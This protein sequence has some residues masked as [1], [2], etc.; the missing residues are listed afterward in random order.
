MSEQ[1]QNNL[2]AAL[3]AMQKECAYVQKGGRNQAQGY[4][5]ASAADV[6]RHVNEAACE[7]ALASFPSVDLLDCIQV[8]TRNGQTNLATVRVTMT[9]VHAPSGER[10]T[11]SALGQ[12]ADPGDKAVAKAQTMA[13]KYAWML[14]LNISTGDD[15]EA[16]E[17]TDRGHLDTPQPQGA[18]R[19][20]VA[21]QNGTSRPPSG[22]VPACPKC[23]GQMWDNR[24]KKT[25]PKAPDFKCKDKEHCDGATWV[26][27]NR[28]PSPAPQ[29]RTIQQA[30][31][32]DAAY[33]EQMENTAFR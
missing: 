25:N 22:D 8:P 12:G 5:Y 28:A 23:G 21:H 4:N 20:P 32:E 16:D 30:F 11:V 2:A 26:Q 13:I 15:P 17:S 1:N 10:L 27:S 33:A 6:L 18:P 19:Q 24:A 29:S 14:A 3:V 9:L 7:N 31:D